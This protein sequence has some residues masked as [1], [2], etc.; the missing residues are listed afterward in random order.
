M[1]Q[2]RRVLKALRRHPEGLT[3]VDFILPNVIDG[4]P[5][6][7]NFPARIKDLKDEGHRIDKDGERYGCTIYKLQQA[8]PVPIPPPEPVI[9]LDENASAD[10]LFDLPEQ[11]PAR[12]RSPYEA[13]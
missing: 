8:A 1:S 10:V 3:R 6:I 9:P 5:P 2:K 7:L 13:A 12:I 11:R 4:G